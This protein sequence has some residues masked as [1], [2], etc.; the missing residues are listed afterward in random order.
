MN[1]FTMYVIVGVAVF[2]VGGIIYAKW[3]EYKRK[4]GL[5]KIAEDL[6]LDYVEDGKHHLFNSLSDLSLFSGGRSRK[7]SQMICGE[8]DEV[9]IGIF[10]YT[11]HSGR[12]DDKRSYTQ[13]VIALQSEQ[14][15]LPQFQMR[16][17]SSILDILG[18]VLGIQNIDF[19][20][21][22]EF[23][24]MFILQ[25]NDEAAIREF[26]DA[27]WLSFLERYK[28]FS[29][30]GRNGALIFYCSNRQIRPSEIKDYLAK[31]YDIY[32]HIIERAAA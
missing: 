17:Q 15:K 32:G 3:H 29:L 21:H 27:D 6:G 4:Q 20:T 23:S 26:F 12:G 24:K 16:P 28:G 9:T 19:E 1:D 8:T 11:Y 5:R 30:E 31:A 18:S 2:I 7:C 10:D 14:I 25:G 22:P 13:S